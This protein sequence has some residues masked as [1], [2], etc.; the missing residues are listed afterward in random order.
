MNHT[1]PSKLVPALIGGAA[2]A[3]LSS[4][5]FI[6]MGNCLC[7]MWVLFGGGLAVYFY[8]KDL[9]PEM[10]LTMGDGVLVGLLAGLF[11]ALFGSVLNYAFMAM[12]SMFPMQDFVQE[13]LES[14]DDIPIEVHEMFDELGGEDMISPMFAVIG[15]GFSLI[16]DSLFATIGGMIGTVIFRKKR[17]QIH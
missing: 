14:Q 17:E 6:N 5:P 8:S 7:C 12:G 16:I 13:M 3:V 2:I 15:L 9:P 10:E 11:G 4:V 1:A